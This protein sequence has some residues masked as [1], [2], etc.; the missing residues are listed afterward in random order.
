MHEIHDRS[1]VTEPLLLLVP[2]PRGTI[3]QQGP[4]RRRV[5]IPPIGLGRHHLAELVAVAH[6]RHAR[7]RRLGPFRRPD[8]V[9][10][11]SRGAL[12]RSRRRRG[13]L[14]AE[15]QFRQLRQFVLVAATVIRLDFPHQLVH[16]R[17]VQ[18]TT[19]R[20]RMRVLGD[21]LPFQAQQAGH[22]VF[23][24]LLAVHARALTRRARH[25]PAAV[26]RHRRDGRR[27][28]ARLRAAM[29]HVVF[30]LAITLRRQ[31]RAD[32]FRQPIHV[33]AADRDLA[34]DAQH[35]GGDGVRLHLPRRLH[36]L[37]Q[38]RRRVAVRPQFQ[39]R[40]LR[41]KNPGG[42]PGN[43]PSAL[44]EGRCCRSSPRWAGPRAEADTS[45]RTRD[46]H[47]P[48]R[49][50][51]LAAASRPRASPRARPGRPPWRPPPSERGRHRVRGRSRPSA[52]G[53]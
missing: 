9:L 4:P 22:L 42:R 45:A 48:T 52:A 40:T 37:V 13:H 34:D 53:R 21:D 15:A 24:P 19:R 29:M 51:P 18:K 3:A 32:L 17:R 46:R 23:F 12:G 39:E 49:V 26:Q 27:R 8:L 1:P 2:D 41:E 33:P 35:L 5:E 25:H 36:D 20:L 11:R 47:A 10:G 28:R 44:R 30:R 7:S 38:R 6:R 16:F 43:E 31:F 14:L 50:A